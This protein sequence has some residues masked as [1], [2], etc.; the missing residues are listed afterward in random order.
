[1]IPDAL[2]LP[3]FSRVARE[4]RSAPS[5][6]EITLAQLRDSLPSSLPEGIASI[7]HNYYERDPLTFNTDWSGTMPM[8]GL[9]MWARRGVPGALDYVTAWF[10]AHLARDP[11]LT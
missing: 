10:E 3:S 11:K 9:T 7:I 2:T 6:K 1:M 5:Y 8:W 4:T